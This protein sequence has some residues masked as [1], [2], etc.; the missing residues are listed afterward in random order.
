MNINNPQTELD[1]ALDEIGLSDKAYEKA[2][3]NLSFVD[4]KAECLRQYHLSGE[5]LNKYRTSDAKLSETRRINNELRRANFLLSNACAFA[6]RKIDDTALELQ[7]I[8]VMIELS[9]DY[10]HAMK[11]TVFTM[12]KEISTKAFNHLGEM[13]INLREEI[14]RNSYSEISARSEL[15]DIPF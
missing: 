13:S 2:L 5:M 7:S 15:N 6:Q 4:L 14:S 1:T 8:K 12:I 9:A 10:T 11:R 3:E